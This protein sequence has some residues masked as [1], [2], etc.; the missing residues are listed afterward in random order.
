MEN[1]VLLNY[2]EVFIISGQAFLPRPSASGAKSMA[3]YKKR[4]FIVQ[5]EITI[6]MEK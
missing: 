1:Y 6:F 2:N 4:L 5:E 3:I